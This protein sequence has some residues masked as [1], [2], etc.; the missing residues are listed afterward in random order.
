[1]MH[2]MHLDCYLVPCAADRYYPGG[3][4]GFYLSLLVSLGTRCQGVSAIVWGGAAAS[5]G[6]PGSLLPHGS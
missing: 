5:H 1:M 6:T 2:S 3:L 4:P